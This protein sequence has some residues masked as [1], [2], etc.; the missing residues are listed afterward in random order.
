M[1]TLPIETLRRIEAICSRFEEESAEGSQPIAGFLEEI[2]RDE[3]AHLLRELVAIDVELCLKRNEP[4]RVTD[5]EYLGSRC[6]PIMPPR[7]IAA[8]IDEVRH[9][10]RP[11]PRSSRYDFIESVG[12]G[13]N[14]DVWRIFDRESQRTLAIKFLRERLR[15]DE[16]AEKRLRREALLT[17]TLQHPGIPPI[18]DRGKLDDGTSFF[19]MKLVGGETFANIL[20]KSSGDQESSNDNDANQLSQHLGIFEQI[21]QTVAYAHAQGVIHRDLKPHNVMVGDF[22]EVQVMDWGMAKRVGSGDAVDDDEYAWSSGGQT[23]PSAIDTLPCSEDDS[24][25]D[26]NHSLTAAGDVLGT[27]AYMSPEQARGEVKRL[28][29]RS[30]VFALGAILYE[31]LTGQRLHGERSIAE[32]IARTATGQ[33]SDSVDRLKS[34]DAHE[35]LRAVCENCL[36]FDPDRRPSDANKISKTIT[37]YLAGAER[38]ARQTEMEQREMTLRATEDRRRRRLQTQTAAAIALVSVIGS[39]VAISQWRK[40]T[41]ANSRAEEALS[42]ADERF[43]QAKSVVDEFFTEV[44]DQQGLLATAPGAQPV[45]RKLLQKA[46]DYYE[47]F[48]AESDNDPKMQ[49]EMAKAYARLGEIEMV[50]DPGGETLVDYQN[51]VIEICDSVLGDSPSNPDFLEARA[52]AFRAIGLWHAFANHHADALSEFEQAQ[53]DL[54]QLVAIRGNTN[55]RFELAKVYQNIGMAAY[56]TRDHSRSKSMLSKAIEVGTEIQQAHADNAEYALQLGRMHN[57]L[58]ILQGWGKKQWKQCDDSFR[59][60]LE[61]TK[62][63]CELQPELLAYREDLARQQ[64]NVAMSSTHMKDFPA[65][66]AGFRACIADYEELATQNPDATK[67]LEGVAFT[68]ANF[69]T[70]LYRRK[71]IDVGEEFIQKSCEAYRKLVELQPTLKRYRDAELNSITTRIHFAWELDRA[72]DM[73][74]DKIVRRAQDRVRHLVDRYAEAAQRY[75]EIDLYRI[76]QA[77]WSG[78]LREPPAETMLRWTESVGTDPKQ[79]ARKPTSHILARALA[80]IR[81]DRHQEALQ[82]LQAAKKGTRSAAQELLMC[83]ARYPTDPVP[84]ESNLRDAEK[85]MKDAR[86]PQSDAYLLQA[87]ALR[88]FE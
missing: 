40:A 55:D 64:M 50:L 68:S 15:G 84:A 81:N 85:L 1:P 35:D 49:L 67:Y 13:G 10:A 70:F 34:C 88:L 69:S 19:S 71:R 61:L 72:D 43:D 26:L 11:R 83:L 48:L 63:A 23:P 2:D 3:R 27:P 25:E 38:R 32:S 52:Q 60:S 76:D 21:A 29:T 31:I 7:S 12:R 22:G 36:R 47:T 87:E 56:D 73:G 51:K 45:R 4:P 62:R 6:S 28:D 41:R 37:D 78:L 80:L 82:T 42:L 44:A 58:G 65:A 59:K 30:D 5:Y 17:G 9:S 66:E 39:G 75:P 77:Y 24:W 8:I 16:A 18:Y 14:G 20:K 53:S 46:R 57:S 79:I 86:G 33:F 74:R 54:E